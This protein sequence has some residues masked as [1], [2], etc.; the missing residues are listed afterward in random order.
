M[1]AAPARPRQRAGRGRPLRSSVLTGVRIS[2]R[3]SATISVR[4]KS[5]VMLFSIDQHVVARPQQIAYPQLELAELGPAPQG[6]TGTP[7]GRVE[8][9]GVTDVE[10]SCRRSSSSGRRTQVSLPLPVDQP[11]GI[12]L[13]AVQQQSHAAVS[14]RPGEACRAG[15]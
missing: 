3:T 8:V 11:S 15:P 7:V 1:L 5:G 12:D 13:S 14:I 6:V 2:S 4:L 10:S 9:G